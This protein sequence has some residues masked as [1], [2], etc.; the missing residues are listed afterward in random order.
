MSKCQIIRVEVEAFIEVVIIAES[1]WEQGR[2]QERWHW[3]SAFKYGG[4]G[5]GRCRGNPSGH[6]LCAVFYRA[7]ESRIGPSPARY[8]RR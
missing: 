1:G 6:S 5:L 2:P 4:M 3:S 8:C 7:Q